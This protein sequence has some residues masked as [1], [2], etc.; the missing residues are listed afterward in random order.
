[1]FMSALVLADLPL[2]F[3]LGRT[4]PF[5]GLRFLARSKL[6]ACAESFV[7]QRTVNA[8]KRAFQAGKLR[9]DLRPSLLRGLDER[10]EHQL[11]RAV[12]RGT[13]LDSYRCHNIS[14][15][16]QRGGRL[17]IGTEPEGAAQI[18]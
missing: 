3:R 14:L 7:E 11:H 6:G 17:G 18:D 12:A 1:M 9:R 2:R 10:A 13:D 8:A 16:E 15:H 5:L 4:H